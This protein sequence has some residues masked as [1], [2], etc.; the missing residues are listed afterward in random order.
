MDRDEVGEG[1]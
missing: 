1:E